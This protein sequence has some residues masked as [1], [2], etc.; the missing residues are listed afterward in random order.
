MQTPTELQVAS[1][2]PTKRE[3]SKPRMLEV[4]GNARKTPTEIRWS[5]FTEVTGRSPGFGT[6]R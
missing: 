5:A 6:D 1:G 3:D 2:L 4:L